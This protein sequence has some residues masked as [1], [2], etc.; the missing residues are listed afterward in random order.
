MITTRQYIDL[1]KDYRNDKDSHMGVSKELYYTNIRKGTI[2][3]GQETFV[4]NK[5]F[6]L[7]NKQLAMKNLNI[8]LEKHGETIDVQAFGRLW[9]K[10][11][12][13]A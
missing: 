13:N 11:T 5:R 3:K 2:E 8:L 7:I 1:L 10:Y 4:H 6:V 9:K 12:D